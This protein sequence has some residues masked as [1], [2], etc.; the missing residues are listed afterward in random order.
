MDLT[1]KVAAL[2]QQG[3]AART[4]HARA[5]AGIAV[6][7]DRAAQVRALLQGEFGVSTVAEARVLLAKLHEEATGEAAEVERLLAEAGGTA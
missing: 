3:D 4:R 2:K 6:A 7:E 1:Q 5:M